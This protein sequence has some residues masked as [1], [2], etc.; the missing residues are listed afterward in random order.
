MFRTALDVHLWNKIESLAN[1]LLALQRAIEAS[2]KR[3]DEDRDDD[4]D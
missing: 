3:A 2:E 4:D 1:A